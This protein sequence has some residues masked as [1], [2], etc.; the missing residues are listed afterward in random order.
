MLVNGVM[1][2]GVVIA[3][4]NNIIRKELHLVLTMYYV[5]AAGFVF[6]VIVW[7]RSVISIFLIVVMILLVC[8]YLLVNVFFRVGEI[9][10]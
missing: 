4:R 3:A 8:A 2:G 7:F 1:I 9:E 6:R 5:G 10:S